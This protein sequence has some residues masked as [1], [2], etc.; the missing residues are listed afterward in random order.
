M[1]KIKKCLFHPEVTI[2]LCSYVGL[3]ENLGLIEHGLRIELPDLISSDICKILRILD[4]LHIN[5]QDVIYEVD[6]II[7]YDFLQQFLVVHLKIYK[8]EVVCE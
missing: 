2:D 6:S 5:W 1:K 3:E 4:E 8:E 7:S